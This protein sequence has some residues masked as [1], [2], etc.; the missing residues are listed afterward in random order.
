[1]TGDESPAA[2]PRRLCVIP[3]DG[4]GPEVTLVAVRVLA[5]VMPE[6]QIE[7]ADAGWKT[8]CLTGVSVP[9][10]T[11]E[12]VRDCG[13]ALFGAVSSPGRKVEG[14]QS[15]ILRIRQSLGLGTN[16]RPV[17]GR[18][19]IPP[20]PDIHLVIVRENS[21]C[22][23][24]AR[25]RMEGEVA[26]AERWISARASRSIG[27]ASARL[28]RLYGKDRITIV[29]KAN[30]LPVT[31]GLFRDCVREAITQWAETRDTMTMDELLVDV[32]ALKLVAEPE[33]FQAIVT[34]N[35]FGDILS[36]LAS[37]WCGGL[38]RAPSLNLG[39]GCAVAEPVH[40][41]APD[42]AGQG[43]ADPTAAILSA[44]LLCRVT[45]N[46]SAIADRIESATLEAIR[47]WGDQPMSTETFGREVIGLL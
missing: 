19:G 15:A 2:R 37:H 45:W 33:R 1:M 43:V 20:R 4:I 36:D 34:T 44:A 27:T 13:A 7:S 39:E 9:D 30:V 18:F 25:E 22:L 8:F 17:D 5:A 40:G 3:G 6:L 28:A 23:Y 12:R 21:E 26:I 41:S 31:D 42:I 24:V 35:L 47:Q 11:L 46:D 38:G 16:L 14:Y 29:H 10:A 32:A